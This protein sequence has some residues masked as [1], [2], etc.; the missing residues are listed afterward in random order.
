MSA[1][2][3]VPG[4]F[5]DAEDEDEPGPVKAPNVISSL[6]TTSEA[7]AEEVKA[8]DEEEEEEEEE[9]D[10]ADYDDLES[11]L[12]GEQRMGGGA[13]LQQKAAASSGRMNLSQASKNDLSRAEKASE[14]KPNHTGRDDRATSEQVRMARALCVS[15][16][17]P[18][19]VPVPQSLTRPKECVWTDGWT[20]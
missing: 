12:L 2:D 14:R 5:D 13:S 3:P 18:T 11:D 19:C 17:L 15:A 7:E 10:D 4:Q 9:E 1:F 16:C 8:E 20:V 6:T